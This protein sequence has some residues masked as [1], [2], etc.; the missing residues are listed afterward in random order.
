[1]DAPDSPANIRRLIADTLED[2]FSGSG[3]ADRRRRYERTDARCTRC[4][5]T[6]MA[7]AVMCSCPAG[8]KLAGQC[9]RSEHSN[10]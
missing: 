7:G 5:D 3:T 4:G 10:G 2:A 6:G 9:F 1:M 8:S